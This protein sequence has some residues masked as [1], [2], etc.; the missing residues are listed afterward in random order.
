MGAGSPRGRHDGAVPSPPPPRDLAAPVPTLVAELV[1]HLGEAAVV[2]LCVALLAGAE[3]EEHLA[4]LPYLTG[5]S[6]EPGAR[7][8]VRAVLAGPVGAHVGGPGPA[9]R[10]ARV[11]G[12][13][14]RR[15]PGRPG[16]A[17]GGDVPQ[18]RHAS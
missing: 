16:L 12:E 1:A 9:L 10:V 15:R 6:F 18:G 11:R 4:E 8:L 7:V 14:G 5:M 3:R 2:E 13:R 17:A